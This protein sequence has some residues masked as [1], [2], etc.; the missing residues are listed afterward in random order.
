MNI[1]YLEALSNVSPSIVETIIATYHTAKATG[2]PQETIKA[3]YFVEGMLE[4]L[5]RINLLTEKELIHL[6]CYY[7]AWFTTLASYQK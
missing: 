2:Y 6:L 5:Y 7:R 3:L 1:M 4:A